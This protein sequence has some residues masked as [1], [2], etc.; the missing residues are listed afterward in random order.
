[1]LAQGVTVAMDLDKNIPAVPGDRTQL[2]QVVVNLAMNAIQ[3]MSHAG[4]ESR[5]IRVSSQL[6]DSHILRIS[7]DDSGPGVPEDERSKLFDSFYT[8]KPDGMGMGLPICRSI[9]ERHGGEI[10]VEQGA[11]G[12]AR[13]SFT[14]PI[15]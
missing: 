10:W 8:T 12:G 13:F 14:L 2:Q 5:I 15:V 6:T 7:M 1:M 11:I 3:A 9:I 4:A